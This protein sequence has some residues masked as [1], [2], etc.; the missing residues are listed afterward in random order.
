MSMPLVWIS[1][2]YKMRKSVL[3]ADIDTRRSRVSIAPIKHELEFY[4]L[5][6]KLQ[7]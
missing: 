6:L 3:A 7:M 2:I 4:E 1:S 5:L